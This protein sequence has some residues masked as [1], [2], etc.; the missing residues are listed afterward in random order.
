MGYNQ[1]G[2]IIIFKIIVFHFVREE[3]DM[4]KRWDIIRAGDILRAG[5][6]YSESVR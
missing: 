1:K 4:P 6:I 3:T 5:G 2:D